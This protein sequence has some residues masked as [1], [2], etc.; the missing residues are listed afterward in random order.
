MILVFKVFVQKKFT[1]VGLTRVLEP[2][3]SDGHNIS[4]GMNIPVYC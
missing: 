1:I 3:W 2:D 4:R